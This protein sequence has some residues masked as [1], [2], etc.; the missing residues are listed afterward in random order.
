[1]KPADAAGAD[2][3]VRELLLYHFCRLQLPTV[4]L[5]LPVFRSH[6]NRTFD[7]YRQK[8]PEATREGYLDSL[9]PVDWYLC[10]GCLEKQPPAWD[11]LFASRTG[12]TDRLLADA[13]RARAIRLYPGQEERQEAVVVE[14]WSRLL[15]SDSP[16]SLPILARYDGQRPLLPWLIRVFENEQLSQLKKDHHSRSLADDEMGPSLPSTT[17]ARWHDL[18]VQTAQAWLRELTDDDVLLLGLRLR[19]NLSQR[20]VARLFGIH[21]GNVTR[22]LDKLSDKAIRTFRAALEQEGWTGDDLS[23]LIRTEMRWL[24][25]DDP[26]FSAEHLATL[27][28]RRGRSLPEKP[29]EPTD[30]P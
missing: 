16:E 13:L 17:G 25:F 18:F 9:Y 28:A 24:I 26:R 12:R 19:Y 7:L 20:E 21:E 10:C 3:P 4:R 29:E 6:L 22:R 8:V 1:M 11:Q 5:T 14:F 2:L 23:S 15:V 30:S 27:L